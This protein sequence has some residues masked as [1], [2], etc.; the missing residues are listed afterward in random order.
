M[1]EIK[2]SID[3]A[4]GFEKIVYHVRFKAREVVKAKFLD[5]WHNVQLTDYLVT[6][7]SGSSLCPNLG[8]ECLVQ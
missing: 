5:R 7:K 6:I 2:I 3:S 1:S 8:W 4:E